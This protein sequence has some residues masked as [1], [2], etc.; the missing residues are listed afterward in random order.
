MRG[1][2]VGRGGARPGV[3]VVWGVAPA[4]PPAT[5]SRW[6]PRRCVA[7]RACGGRPPRLPMRS[8]VALVA[9]CRRPSCPMRTPSSERRTPQ[10]TVK[11]HRDSSQHRWQCRRWQIAVRATV[12]ARSSPPQPRCCRRMARCGRHQ[13]IPLLNTAWLA[14]QRVRA[15]LGVARCSTGLRAKANARMPLAQ[16]CLAWIRTDPTLT[17]SH[18]HSMGSCL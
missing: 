7:P 14:P 17:T 1:G 18:P 16:P 8:E 10:A 13:Q 11:R 2:S 6:D 15:T 12:T 4:Q 9:S 3:R 5:A